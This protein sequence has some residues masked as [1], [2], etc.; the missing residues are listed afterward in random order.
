MYQ[1]AID[2]LK[3]SF[4]I[5]VQET[6]EEIEEEPED[7]VYIYGL[8]MDGARWDR[9]TMTIADQFPSEMYDKMPVIHFKPQEDFKRSEDD[10]ACPCYKT[11]TRAGVLSTTGQSTNYIVAIDTPSQEHP[12][13]W[14]Q[15]AAAF[16]C[17]LND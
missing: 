7:G 3:F 6:S 17:M 1:I 4:E 16:V 9:D 2:R 15:R 5:L 11:T 10:Y 14:V 8:F 12:K 13:I